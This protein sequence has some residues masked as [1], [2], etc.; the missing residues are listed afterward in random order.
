VSPLT[1]GLRY[2]AA[3]DIREIFVYNGGFRGRVIEHSTTTN[4]GCHDN[5]I[6]NKIGY[7]LACIRNISEMLES[8]KGFSGSG[9]RMMSVKFYHGRYWLPWQRNLSQ[10]RL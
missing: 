5:E 10:N 4:F 8:N 1:Q 7:N 9:Y 3:C 6:W 2:R